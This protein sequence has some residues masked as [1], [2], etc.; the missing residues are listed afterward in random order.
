MSKLWY[1]AFR[2]AA[3]R[4][5]LN[6]MSD[7]LFLKLLYYGKMGKKLDLSNPKTFT[8]KMQWLKI[9]NKALI[10]TKMVDKFA[11]KEYVA[12]RIGEEY[13]IPTL[14]V[15]DSFEDIDFSK[16]P[17]Q[18]VIKC[19]NDSGGLVICKDKSKLDASATALKIEKCLNAKYYFHNREWPYKDVKPRIIV[20]KYMVDDELQELRD[21]KF[22]CFNGKVEFFKVD[23][24]RQSC[25]RANYYS[26]NGELLPVG[27]AAYPPDPKKEIVFPKNLEKM[28]EL[29]GVLSKG[30]P[31]LRVDFY[32]VNGQIYFGELTFYPASGTGK[33]TDDRY[34]KIF[35]DLIDLSVL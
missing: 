8:E 23:F 22:F 18:F 25:H 21:Y 12:E 11:A 20:E 1:R 29:S 28:I 14:G 34:D 7:E 32:E 30:Y 2:F 16:L 31:F 24:D 33:W 19:T 26:V 17:E 6:Y 10:L 13:I 27:E 15:W 4:G 9:H 35:G 5:L 3:N